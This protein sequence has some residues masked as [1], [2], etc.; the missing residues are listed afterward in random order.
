MIAANAARCVSFSRGGCPGALQTLRA[1]GVELE[2]P[3]PHNLQRHSA[4]LRRF[5]APDA[6][7][8]RRQRHQPAHLR[9]VLR[10]LGRRSNHRSIKIGPNR[11]RH[12]EPPSFATLNQPK[13]DS[14][15]PSRV[16]LSGIGYKGFC[17]A[18]GLSHGHVFA[19]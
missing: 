9:S 19:R 5:G 3:V 10:P 12:G 8:N 17:G 14:G 18:A 1:I 6:V 11:N 13:V 4:D 16:K 2:N 15:T 7:I